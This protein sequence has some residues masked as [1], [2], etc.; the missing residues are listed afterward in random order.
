M[1][2]VFSSEFVQ[3]LQR[4]Y[5]RRQEWERPD[6][7][8]VATSPK[9]SEHRAWIEAQVA[10]LDDDARSKMI[11]RL[12]G[13]DHFI[14]TFNELSVVA[15]LREAG[16]D[17]RYEAKLPGTNLTPDILLE[18][19]R[20]GA[21]I[22]VWTRR[23]SDEA[24]N[25]GRRWRELRERLRPIPSSFGLRVEPVTRAVAIP[26]PAA[27]VAKQLT[28]ELRGW[29]L[30]TTTVVGSVFEHPPYRFIVVAR[31]L[32]LQT[33]LAQTR[34][35]GWV[36]TDDVLDGIRDKVS[37]Y[38]S[39]ARANN[40]SIVVA[41]AAETVPI[42]VDFLRAT[43]AGTQTMS[44]TFNMFDSGVIAE[45]SF[46]L[47]RDDTTP[48]IDPVLSAVAWLAAPGPEPTLEIFPN[49]GAERPLEWPTTRS[50]TVVS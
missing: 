49:A 37:R 25:E 30:S 36:S 44:A 21:V 11:P 2:S 34:S 22:D 29:L 17:P 31:Q 24:R 47:R 19:P 27:A 12:R 33:V 5:A 43:L 35:G 16:F 32:G 23:V 18:S 8:F 20:G 14:T 9:R 13:D 6:I 15:V 3:E 38:A 45:S 7:Y 41:V 26:P 28:R 42:D 48:A 39:V 10:A 4:R 46:T 50:I 1:E 40:T